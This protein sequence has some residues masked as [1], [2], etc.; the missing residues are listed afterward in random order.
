MNATPSRD[1]MHR[2]DADVQASPLFPFIQTEVL[3]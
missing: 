1:P 2:D 3:H